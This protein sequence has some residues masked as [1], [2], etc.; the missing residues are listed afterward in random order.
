MTTAV[1]KRLASFF[2]G[3]LAA[4]GASFVLHAQ[5]PAPDLILTNGKIITVDERFTIAQAVP[6]GRY[7][8]CGEFHGKGIRA[9]QYVRACVNDVEPSFALG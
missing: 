7:H 4:I 9:T 3:T 2:A 8:S 5:Q 6:P 1:N